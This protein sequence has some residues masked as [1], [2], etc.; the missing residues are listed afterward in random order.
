M[1]WIKPN[2]IEIE[3]TDTEEVIEYCESLGWK[4]AEQ[5]RRGR[6]RKEVATSSSD[7]D[8]GDE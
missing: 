5:K 3:T 2:G 7:F 4:R 6:P 8:Q 1:K